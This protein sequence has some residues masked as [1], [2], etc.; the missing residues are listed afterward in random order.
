MVA[1]AAE[2]AAKHHFV[3]ATK[4][5]ESAAQEGINR[6][7][8]TLAFVPAAVTHHACTG[9]FIRIAGHIHQF[10]VE[11]GFSMH[12][13]DVRFP[14]VVK[15]WVRLAKMRVLSLSEYAQSGATVWLRS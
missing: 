14:A 6:I 10:A 12:A 9:V 1:L 2:A 13:V 3:L 15:R 4:E 11:I 5:I 7:L 8:F